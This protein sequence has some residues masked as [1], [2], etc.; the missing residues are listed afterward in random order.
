MRSLVIL[1]VVAGCGGSKPAPAPSPPELRAVCAKAIGKAAATG[2]GTEKFSPEDQQANAKVEAAMV[3]S[4]VATKWPAPVLQCLETGKTREEL[5]DCT[6]LLTAEQQA[7]L[8]ERVG[9][10]ASPTEPA[11]SP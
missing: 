8:L 2:R 4:C 11:S 5:R 10:A 7:E 6:E 3:E 1:V 9:A